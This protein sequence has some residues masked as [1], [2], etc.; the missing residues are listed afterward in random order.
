MGGIFFKYNWYLKEKSLSVLLAISNE[1]VESIC[2]AWSYPVTI[3]KISALKL[4]FYLSKDFIV[5]PVIV[6]ILSL[7]SILL[8]KLIKLTPLFLRYSIYGFIKL[9][10]V[11]PLITDIF[12]KLLWVIRCE[13][14]ERIL[15]TLDVD[16]VVTIIPLNDNINSWKLELQSSQL[17]YS[18]NDIF[19]RF[20]FSSSL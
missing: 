20:L 3:K 4:I 12:G 14:N 10:L 5:S 13:N 17:I 8:I 15:T 6:S 1:F 2:N 18:T 11:G 9:S 19:L 7:I 16:L